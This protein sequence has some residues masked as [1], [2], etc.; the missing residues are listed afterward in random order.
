[1]STLVAKASTKK[2]AVKRPVTC[3]DCAHCLIKSGPDGDG[4]V[5]RCAEGQWTDTRGR[6]KTIKVA[7]VPPPFL[8]HYAEKAAGCAT[9]DLAD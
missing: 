4:Y 2:T 8:L 1:M 9:S 5:V 7:T 3:L 6:A